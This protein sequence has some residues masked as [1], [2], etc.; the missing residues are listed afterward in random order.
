[1]DLRKKLE[2]ENLKG[3]HMREFQANLSGHK[4]QDITRIDVVISLFFKRYTLLRTYYLQLITYN[5]PGEEQR[6]HHY[7]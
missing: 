7:Q 6:D 2:E 1:M 5:S 3:S 4:P